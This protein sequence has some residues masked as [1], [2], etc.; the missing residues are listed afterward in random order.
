MRRVGHDSKKS[1]PQPGQPKKY[2]IATGATGENLS[3]TGADFATV[4]IF[5]RSKYSTSKFSLNNPY[6]DC[7][8]TIIVMH[9][10]NEC[11]KRKK[12]ASNGNSV[13][14]LFIIFWDLKLPLSYLF[15]KRYFQITIFRLMLETMCSF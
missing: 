9:L 3:S 7:Y 12:L 2:F 1:Y 14:Y 8:M 6:I 11:F 15:S 10:R 4:A 5:V 13:F